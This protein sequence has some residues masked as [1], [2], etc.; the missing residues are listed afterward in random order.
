[1]ATYIKAETQG[2][3]ASFGLLKVHYEDHNVVPPE[4]NREI[5][6]E[7][8]GKLV[9]LPTGCKLVRRRGVIYVEAEQA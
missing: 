7:P 8:D 4:P 1:M 9:L 6:E 3:P 2:T 5:W